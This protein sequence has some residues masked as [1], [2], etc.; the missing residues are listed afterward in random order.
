[1]FH[2]TLVPGARED[3]PFPVDT[4]DAICFYSSATGGSTVLLT[5][6]LN[7]GGGSSQSSQT[8]GNVGTIQF[9]HPHAIAVS[10]VNTGSNPVGW[11]LVS[12]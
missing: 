11:T 8:V 2:G 5:I 12:D 7:A 4:F 1:M 10:L 6:T 9:P 3:I